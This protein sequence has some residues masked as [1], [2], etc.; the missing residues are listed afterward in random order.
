MHALLTGSTGLVGSAVVAS[1]RGAGHHVTRLVRA[2]SRAD[3]CVQWDPL[4]GKLDDNAITGVES[5]VHLAGE[6][7]AGRWTRRKKERIRSSRVDG[8]RTLCQAL[9]RMT[10][11]PQVLI[12]ASAIGFYGDRGDE[13]LTEDSPP[14]TGFL[15]EVCQAWEAATEPATD[16]GI[17][18][19]KLRIGVVLAANGGALAKMLTPFRL[20]FGGR[21]GSGRQYMS[22]ITL[23]DVVGAI[24]H[25]I[26]NESLAG[27]VNAT[28]PNPV[29]NTEFTKTLGRALRRPTILPLPSFAARAAMGEMANDLLLA[30]TR[31]EPTRLLD[32]GY[33]FQHRDLNQ[34]LRNI[35]K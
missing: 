28:A 31:T 11:P 23:D 1:M 32:T 10:K 12:S 24:N 2:A 19:V 15:P 16:A 29:T 20:G 26:T 8:T 4:A 21:I 30:S 3:D 5:V 6:N 7:I 14:G 33:A 25:A 9:A 34:A 27:P 18:V 13:V 35:L 22:W 17:R